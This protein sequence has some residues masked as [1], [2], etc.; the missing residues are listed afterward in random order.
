M[1]E[2]KKLE[3]QTLLGLAAENATLRMDVNCIRGLVETLSQERE[4]CRF[5][6]NMCV[7]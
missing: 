6:L 4:D 1:L 3:L 2:A 5:Q 7:A